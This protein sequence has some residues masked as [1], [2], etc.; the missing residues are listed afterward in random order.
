MFLQ[1]FQAYY[2]YDF[3]A[4]ISTARL[5]LLTNA[6]FQDIPAEFSAQTPLN[7]PESIP[8]VFNETI[9]VVVNKTTMSASI[10]A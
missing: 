5:T 3:S 10:Q 8:S 1:N 9:A 2:E 7:E 4:P 6:L